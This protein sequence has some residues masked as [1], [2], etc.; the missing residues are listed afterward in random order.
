[1]KIQLL[2]D[3]KASWIVPYAEQ[4][5]STLIQLKHESRLIFRHDEVLEGDILCLLSCEKVFKN[6]S[7]NK[8][9]LVVHE[10]DLPEG[11]GWSPVTW[12]I[13]EGK[14]TIP[15]TLFEAADTIDSGQ[16]YSQAYISLDGTELL[17]E[18]KHKQGA[19][20]Q[21]LILSFIECLPDI[22]VRPQSGDETFYPRRRPDD[23]RLD[24][25]KSLYEQFDLLRV[26]DNERYPAHFTM[27]NKEYVI[28]IYSRDDK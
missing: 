3:N 25:H 10:S 14:S 22:K 20:T 6:L 12:Q 28:K 15:I 16:I 24:V 11:K 4:L 21:S 19:V 17:D 23:S 2:V 9:N 1:M 5:C 8:F 18:I 27:R 7:L 13:L 26:C